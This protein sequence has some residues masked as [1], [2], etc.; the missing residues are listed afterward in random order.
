MLWVMFIF[1]AAAGLMVIGF[2][3]KF[4]TLC[5]IEKYGYPAQNAL[6]EGAVAV[7]VLAIF[8]GI[9]RIF[10]GWLSDHIGRAKTMF[11]LFGLQAIL[12]ASFVYLTGISVTMIYVVM[13]MIGLC[14]GACFSLFPSTSADFFGAKNAG[15]NYGIL[16]TSYG[17]G[18]ILGPMLS[19]YMLPATPTVASYAMPGLILGTLVG[20]AAVMALIIKAPK[21]PASK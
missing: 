13:A 5:L 14:F 15:A 19:A 12:M 3:N 6:L 11:I 17:L 4:A 7:S 9:G 1:T 16:F 10:A 21:A 20:I 8:N 2:L 18:G